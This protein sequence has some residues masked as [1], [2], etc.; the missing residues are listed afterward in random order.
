MQQHLAVC[1]LGPFNASILHE[2]ATLVSECGCNIIDCRTA[3]LGEMFAVMLLLSGEWNAIAKAE[4]Q[5]PK[6][7]ERAKWE[8]QLRRT[9]TREPSDD[10]IPYSVHVVTLDSP[11]IIRDITQFFTQKLIRIEE[12]YTTSYSAPIT[13]A[14][15]VSITMTLSLSTE[16]H[17][18]TLREEFMQFCDNLNLDAIL[19][20]MKA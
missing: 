8:L 15:M 7:A 17:I 1:G 5:L 12:L 16:V 19:E 18:G 3:A 13:G 9:K 10:L 2:L 11:G 6:L 4:H 20:P 14:I